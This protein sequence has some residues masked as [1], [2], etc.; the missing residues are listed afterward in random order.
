M[1]E[2][3][4]AGTEAAKAASMHCIAVTNTFPGE[5][6]RQADRIVDSLEEVTVTM[7]YDLV[8]DPSS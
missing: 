2:D 3:S 6:L 8:A 5:H 4:I 1:I 7:L